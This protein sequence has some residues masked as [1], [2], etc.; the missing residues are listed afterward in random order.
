M[1]ITFNTNLA[2]LGAQRNIGIASNAASSSLSK[3]SSGSRVPQA[4][5]DAAG[6]AIGSKLKSEVAGLTQAS[7]N[8]AQAI[9]LLQIADGALSTIGD[10]LQRMKALAVQ[11]SSGQLDDASRSLLNQEFSG[12]NSEISRVA[13]LSNFNGTT[14]LAGSNTI[15]ANVN[16][17]ASVGSATSIKNLVGEGVSS[18]NLA[19]SFSGDAVS[20]SYNAKGNVLTMTNLSTG[21]SDS[22]NIGATAVAAGST[23]TVNF[24]NLGATVVLNENF[25]KNVSTD[26]QNGFRTQTLAVGG[27]QAAKITS[28]S[29]EMNYKFSATSGLTAASANSV[30]FAVNATNADEATITATVGGRAFSVATTAGATGGTVDLTTTGAKNITLTDGAGSTIELNFSVAAAF[31]DG[32]AATITPTVTGLN[33]STVDVNANDVT[34]TYTAGGGTAAVSG[35][36]V[37]NVTFGA[38]SGLQISDFAG[39]TGPA[40]SAATAASTTS[41]TIT[42]GG[43][44]FTSST[45]NRDFTTVGAKTFSYSD[46]QGNSF[47]LTYTVSGVFANGN[48]L[49]VSAVGVDHTPAVANATAQVT[50]VSKGTASTFDFGDV[51][52]GAVTWTTTTASTSTASI[53]L[54]GQTFTSGNV[55]LTT[56][57]EK[58]VTLTNGTGTAATSITY[59]FNL[60]GAL[61]DADTF[62]QE[63]GGLGQIVGVNTVNSGN[64]TFDFK[65]GSGTSTNDSIAFTL[66]SA[67]ADSLGIAAATI[68][69]AANANT[70][71][72]LV[73]NAIT[74]VASRRADI[75]AAQSRLDFASNSISVSIE[76]TTAAASALLDVDV[77]AEITTFTNKNV[78]M[79]A[80]I[81]LL[82]QANQQPALLLRLLQ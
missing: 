6:L 51:D 74:A 29:V 34:F 52:S 61:D 80:G 49:T 64:T 25:D 58:T 72:G 15:T 10:V 5:D 71:I 77:S 11:S 41:G 3:L 65:V 8:A 35:I 31:A 26:M 81:S 79:Q 13:S 12:L 70:A 53:T 60:T 16:D 57:G 43:N 63:I 69:T 7:N 17:T 78:L 73:N 40:V 32:D 22:V 28:S 33:T 24:G 47:D 46:G 9:S 38:N 1:A 82:G 67:T 44:T 4:K 37:S 36:A 68:D 30:S 42:I 55:D 23:Q 66:R 21:Q 19:A 62:T 2:A 18:I 39:I 76:N 50:G 14:L 27:A 56:V 20:L 48:T 59:K 54:N 45:A 75:G